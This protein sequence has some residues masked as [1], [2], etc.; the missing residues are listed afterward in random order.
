MEAAISMASLMA[1]S[2]VW[3]FNFQF[4]EIK[5]L[6]AMSRAE[7]VCILLPREIKDGAK[8]AV[9]ETNAARERAKNFMVMSNEYG[10]LWLWYCKWMTETKD[11]PMASGLIFV[12]TTDVG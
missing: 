3:G 7:L 10:W 11:M 1:S 6:R 9:E 8:A 4:P 2:L 12:S 5:G